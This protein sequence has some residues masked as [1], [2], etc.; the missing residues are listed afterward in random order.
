LPPT[1]FVSFIQNHD[2][3]GNRAFGDRLTAF[4]SPDALRAIISIYLLLPQIPMLFMGEEFGASTPF[5]FFAHFKSDLADAV[6]EGRR[7]EFAKFPEFQDPHKRELIPD[8]TSEATFQSAKLNWAEIG[9]QSHSDWLALYRQLLAIRHAEIIPRL[10]N[11]GEHCGSY[12]I[13]G[14]GAVSV[15]WTMGDGTCLCLVANLS[16]ARLGSTASHG[17]RLWSPGN[18]GGDYL[19]PWTVI[20]TVADQDEASVR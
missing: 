5:P 1:A 9:D 19:E 16:D 6:R 12:K 8:P 3:V 11:I 7:A 2:Q 15:R 20:W 13:L 17:R 4:A 14:E 18:G 10:K